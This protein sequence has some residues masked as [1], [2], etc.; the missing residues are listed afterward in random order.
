MFN[1]DEHSVDISTFFHIVKATKC[2]LG[3]RLVPAL[4]RNVK[5]WDSSL[6]ELTTN[7]KQIYK[8]NVKYKFGCDLLKQRHREVLWEFKLVNIW[9]SF[10]KAND[11]ELGLISTDTDSGVVVF[12]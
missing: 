12:L 5:T 8:I 4:V 10:Q 6:L 9:E 2:P 7:Q 3:K 1:S 11:V